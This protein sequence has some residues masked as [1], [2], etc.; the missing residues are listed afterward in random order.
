MTGAGFAIG[1]QS[2]PRFAF[3]EARP[4]GGKPRKRLKKPVLRAI[5]G[6][7]SSPFRE[8]LRSR[9]YVG[10]E[11]IFTAAAGGGPRVNGPF[12][13]ESLPYPLYR[14]ATDGGAGVTACG[15]GPCHE[16]WPEGA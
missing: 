3:G 13:R 7:R 16:G 15:S 11:L 14:T 5:S 12:C 8:P 2:R 4:R 1:R 9:F 6:A 10:C